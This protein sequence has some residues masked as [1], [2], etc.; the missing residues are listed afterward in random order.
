MAGR[1]REIMERPVGRPSERAGGLAGWRA[2]K[3]ASERVAR[4]H[5]APQAAA[6]APISD[7]L[8][9]AGRGAAARSPPPEE[10]GGGGGGGGGGAK[11]PA[12]GACSRSSAARGRMNGGWM[13][14]T[15]G[16]DNCCVASIWRLGGAGGEWSATICNFCARRLR[17]PSGGPESNNRAHNS[18]LGRHLGLAKCRRQLT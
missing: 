14:E 12:V 13:N 1:E 11:R 15:D 17:R 6:R 10:L 2:G 9:P 8:P 3:R 18:N 7:L 5:S 16:Q 4:A